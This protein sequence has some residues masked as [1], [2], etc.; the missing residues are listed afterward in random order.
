[1]VEDFS[2]QRDSASS[3]DDLKTIQAWL[4]KLSESSNREETSVKQQPK[5]ERKSPLSKDDGS[6][7]QVN[8]P[9]LVPIAKSSPPPPRS[10]PAAIA[11]AL[12]K[13]PPLKRGYPARAPGPANIMTTRV[14]ENQ[15]T[16]K[17]Y[18]LLPVRLTNLIDQSPAKEARPTPIEASAVAKSPIKANGVQI[19]DTSMDRYYSALQHFSA[20]QQLRQQKALMEREQLRALQRRRLERVMEGQRKTLQ[21]LREAEENRSRARHLQRRA[22]KRWANLTPDARLQLMKVRLLDF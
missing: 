11:R 22:E 20:T 2:Q 13:P 17:A 19:S 8:L 9:P 12:P 15:A 18:L 7:S 5:V 10:T 21:K 16:N 14:K 3:N 4:Q 1:M 6:F